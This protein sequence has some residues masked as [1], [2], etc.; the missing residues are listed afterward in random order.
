MEYSSKT[1]S[2]AL[3]QQISYT[4]KNDFERFLIQQ[5][6]IQYFL[7]A[8]VMVR[9]SFPDKNFRS[10][11]ENTTLGN[12][13]YLYKVCARNEEKTI[14]QLL[15]EYNKRRIYLVHKMV[16]DAN[17]KRLQSN[18]KEANDMGSTIQKYLNQLV[19]DEYEVK[20]GEKK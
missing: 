19:I 8:L 9:T 13:I 2:L 17:Y 1:I 12:L 7:M 20:L 6:I 18:I 10:W 16:K 3:L 5:N 4:G 14:V 15:T 11:I